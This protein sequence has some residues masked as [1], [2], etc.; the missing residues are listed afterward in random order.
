MQI[1]SRLFINKII[2]HKT[3]KHT[4]K[5]DKQ[6]RSKI[7]NKTRLNNIRLTNARSHFQSKLKWLLACVSQIYNFID[8]KL[9]SIF[10]FCQNCSY[11]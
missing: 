1:M 2:Y 6:R 10:V 7:N 5:F 9:F 8:K 3:L 4:C 11:V